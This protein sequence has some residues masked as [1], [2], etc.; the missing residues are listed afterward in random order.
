MKGTDIQEI[1]KKKR[2]LIQLVERYG[3]TH[4]AVVTY[5]QELDILLNQWMKKQQI[6]NKSTES[7]NQYNLYIQNN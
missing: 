2:E 3:I 5:S 6:Q 1:T 4:K 7:I